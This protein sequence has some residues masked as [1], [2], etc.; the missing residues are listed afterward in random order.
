[1]KSEYLLG[2]DI[3][4][5]GC[6]STLLE[7][8]GEIKGVISKKYETKHPKKG[9]AEQNPT[10]WYGAFVDSV[11]ELLLK[12]GVSGE[13]VD[14]ISIDGMMNTPT[15]VDEDGKVLRSSIL[16]MDRRS[17]SQVKK[18]REN[19]EVL[20][21][22]YNPIT[23]VALLPKML[24]IKEN[25]NKIWS[26]TNYILLPKD[27]IRSKIVESTPVTDYSDASATLLLDLQKFSWSEEICELTGIERDKLPEI[28]PSSKISGRLSN[29]AARELGLEKG[30]PVITGCSDAAADNLAAGVL[31]PGQVLLRMGTSGALYL[32]T[33]RTRT[34]KPK[35][36]YILKHFKPEL[37]LIH[38]LSPTG[39]SKSWFQNTF[40]NK[41]GPAKNS[42]EELN[43][44]F[45]E[46]ARG[47]PIGSQGLIFHPFLGGEHTPRS[48]H[49]LKGS[50]LGLDMSHGI[51]HF[52]RAI[53]EGTAFSLKE[54]FEVIESQIHSIDSLRLVG[55][56]AK[57]D[58]WRSIIANV[59]GKKIEVPEYN[60][61]SVGAAI[62]GGIGSEIFKSA[63]KAVERCIRIKEREKPDPEKQKKYKK[64]Y[65]KYLES[66]DKLQGIEY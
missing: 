36:H 14:S 38:L 50:F 65:R 13:S 5:S 9:W 15:L 12:T 27:Y 34:K 64:V 53:L 22:V 48:E 63:E 28:V 17:D 37:S 10:D 46:M 61:A 49:D 43:E 42:D 32:V 44:L 20:K 59:L 58:L 45:E 39:L 11:R 56:G 2:V 60:N 51:S 26:E 33:D 47:P 55:G 57:S 21:H 25:Q 19:S 52:A 54:C 4:T 16:W 29:T 8:E 7:S 24:W 6:R 1:M 31:K 3:G 62:L 30:T 40:L 66:L 35:D 18:L 41:I 23:P